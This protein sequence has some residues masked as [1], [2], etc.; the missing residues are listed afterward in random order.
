MPPNFS[1]VKDHEVFGVINALNENGQSENDD[2]FV[3][4]LKDL[5]DKHGLEILHF[6]NIGL[7]LILLVE[8]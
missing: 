8:K 7:G 6:L 1:C 5:Y 4:R 3:L 2:C